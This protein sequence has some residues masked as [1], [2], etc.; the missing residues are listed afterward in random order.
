MPVTVIGR[1]NHRLPMAE[2]TA[3]T[4]CGA[5]IVRT[6]TVPIGQSE[7]SMS[8]VCLARRP[9]GV[10]IS[11]GAPYVVSATGAGV[12]LVVQPLAS[13]TTSATAT[14]SVVAVRALRPALFAGARNVQ[15]N[16]ELEER[17]PCGHRVGGLALVRFDGGAGRPCLERLFGFPLRDD[18]V[19]VFTFDRA[20][21]LEAEETGLAVDGMCTMREP[22]LQF[23]ASVG[24][25]LDCVD[26]HHYVWAGH[27][28]QV[29][30]RCHDPR[31]ADPS[32]RRGRSAGPGA[33]VD[34]AGQHVVAS[35]AVAEAA[36]Q[37]L[38]LRR[39]VAP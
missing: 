23:R 39:T 15:Y 34:G 13:A 2:V 5:A 17:R 19:A 31:P 16:L 9:W 26:L 20:Q 6:P 21:Q 27:A 3:S 36:R 37:G 14:D 4:C 32:C 18:E 22:L 28:P 38:Y 35:A 7:L 30:V 29:T 8:I 25:D 11:I 1:S 24:R 12:A 33:R 10:L